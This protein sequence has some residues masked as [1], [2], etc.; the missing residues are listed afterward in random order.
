MS[1]QY[2]SVPIF[3]GVMVVFC[4]NAIA[5]KDLIYPDHLS[6]ERVKP[7]SDIYVAEVLKLAKE[8]KGGRYASPF[9]GRFK[10]LKSLR[11]EFKE[12]AIFEASTKVGEEAHAGCPIELEQGKSYL[13]FFEKEKGKLT[14][15]SYTTLYRPKIEAEGFIADLEKIRGVP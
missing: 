7:Y 8:H 1:F 4:Q 13:L 14:I 11:G 15:P 6:K 5:C 10:V 9:K 2:K 3:L 12:G